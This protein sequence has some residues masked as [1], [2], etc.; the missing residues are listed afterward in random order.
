MS[1]IKFDFGMIGL[2][3]MGSNLLLNMADHGFSVIGYDKNPDKTK[4]FEASA[5]KNTIVKGVNNLS[6]MIGLLKIP[7]KIMMLVPA[8]SPVDS[9]ISDLL[10]LVE[11]GD[12]IIDGGNSHY[13][14]TLKRIKYL[15]EKELHFMGIGIS[16]GE[17]GA[18]R[19]P[20]I[21][22]GGDKEAYQEVS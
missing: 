4:L 5:E 8:G 14:D 21:M 16:G 3:V 12:I 2:G 18:R 9:V 15:E 10:P 6:E 20:S 19:G 13:T 17:E 22:P 11:K 7:R 1:D